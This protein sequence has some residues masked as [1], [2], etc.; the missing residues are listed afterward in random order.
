MEEA[1]SYEAWNENDSAAPDGYISEDE[2]DER[3]VDRA[4]APLGLALDHFSG[5]HAAIL[6]RGGGHWK[7]SGRISHSCRFL[8]MDA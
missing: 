7:G 6:K 1:M 4:P 2:S 8:T 5:R 3:P